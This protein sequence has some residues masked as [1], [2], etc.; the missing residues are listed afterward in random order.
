MLRKLPPIVLKISFHLLYE[1]WCEYTK[2]DNNFRK[3]EDEYMNGE[4]ILYFGPITYRDMESV[5]DCKISRLVGSKTNNSLV[6]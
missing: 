3:V 1:L 6:F 5:I 4:V 2:I